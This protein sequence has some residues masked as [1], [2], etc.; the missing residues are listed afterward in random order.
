MQRY[1]AN[2]LLTMIASLLGVTIIVFLLIRLI[3]GTIVEQMMGTEA[4]TSYETVESLRRYFG[5]DQPVY[6]Q[7]YQ[8]IT[9]V[10][11][12]DLGHSWRTAIPVLEFILSRLPVTLELAAIAIIVALLIGVPAGIVSAIKHNSPVD[13]LARI[14]ALTGL[15]IPVFW[16]GTMF[17][18]V[19]SLAFRWAP[20][21]GWV[22]PL[23]DLG[24]NLNM[25]L[26]PGFCLGTASAAVIMRMTRSCMLEVLRQEYIR[27]ARAKGL[28]E[29]VVLIAHAL[30]NAM[31]PVVTVAGLQM[32]YLLGGTVVVEEV[33]SLP[34]IGRLLLWAIYQRDYPSVQG[35]VL[36]VAVMFMAVNLFVDVLYAFLDP[37]IRYA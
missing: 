4:L 33:F 10:L 35:T 7:Y 37:R 25:M 11:V 14:I 6:V 30:K 23:K 3:P 36:F 15:S 27:T 20:A 2:R 26:L 16:Q 8:W 9:R 32:G 34:G 28:A 29:R 24:A 13:S 31:I 19:L 1:I 17:I 5:L 21:M 18:L 22:S 12:G